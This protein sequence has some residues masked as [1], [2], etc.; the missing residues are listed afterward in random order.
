METYEFGIGPEQYRPKMFWGAR[1]LVQ[2]HNGVRE[3][4]LLP[5]RQC[6]ERQTDAKY[7]KDEMCD[8][9]NNIAIPAIDQ[10]MKEGFFDTPKPF[11]MES[12]DKA[13]LCTAS[14][15]N[16]GGGYVYIGVW[17]QMFYRFMRST[18]TVSADCL[19][20]DYQMLT[21]AIQRNDWDTVE[22]VRDCLAAIFDKKYINSDDMSFCPGPS[23]LIAPGYSGGILTQ[24]DGT[25]FECIGGLPCSEILAGNIPQCPDDCPHK[26]ACAPNCGRIQL[27]GDMYYFMNDSF[28]DPD[29]AF[30]PKKVTREEHNDTNA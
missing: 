10:K 15:Q 20:E 25:D 7:S 24:P 23:S 12:E 29:E 8:W 4:L 19:I 13:F 6:F 27:K 22:C 30:A 3:L 16:S 11:S 1:A 14:S 21:D 26:G 9:I 2:S 28:F 5:D 17:E 18:V